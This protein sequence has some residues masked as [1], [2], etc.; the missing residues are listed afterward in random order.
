MRFGCISAHSSFLTINRSQP[1]FNI[2]C[3]CI[4]H[5]RN[6]YTC[7]H[8]L[9]VVMNCIGT[10]EETLRRRRKTN[11]M[12]RVFQLFCRATA[13]ILKLIWARSHKNLSLHINYNM[14]MKFLSFFPSFSLALSLIW[15]PFVCIDNFSRIL[16]Y[17][18]ETKWRSL[19][20]S[21]LVEHS[22]LCY[23]ICVFGFM[24]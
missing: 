24:T 6:V 20:F 13:N 18:N 14:H 7:F 21:M 8:L 3:D 22:T 15:F 4:L 23:C 1:S 16:P 9:I 19:C 5:F 2:H 17:G 11:R 10:S 12:Q